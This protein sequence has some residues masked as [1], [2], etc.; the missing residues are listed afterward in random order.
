MNFKKIGRIVKGQ[1]GA[2]W[3]HYLFRFKISGAC[4]VY[5]LNDLHEKEDGELQEFATF[6]LDKS[7]I[8]APHSN[9]VMFGNEYYDPTDTYPLLYCNVYN[10]YKKAEDRRE[11]LCC[12]YRLQQNGTAFTATLVQLIQIGFVN[13]HALWLSEREDGDARPY[14]NFTIDRE[15]GIYYAFTMRDSY[16]TTRYF[17]FSLPRCRDGEMDNMYGVRKVTLTPADILDYFDCDYHH[18]VQGACT[19]NGEIYSLEGFTEN[20]NNPAAFR[21]ISPAEK[22]Q[23]Q[24]V[25]LADHNVDVEPE[26]ID[27][28]GD[29]C[30]FADCY[31]NLYNIEF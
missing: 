27:F 28:R 25:M 10:N 5:D 9:A 29:I 24:C 1:D 30:Y 31:G 16:H 20:V 2:I 11:G 26:L 18:F 22:A 19:H 23:K 4:F 7:D 6:R 3:D 14:G 17:S 13:D 15:K 12:V 8:L 21:L